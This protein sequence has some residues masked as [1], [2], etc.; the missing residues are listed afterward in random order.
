MSK[1]KIGVYVCACGINIGSK[2]DVDAVADFAAGLPNV[3][4][5]RASKYT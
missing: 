1:P 5:A 3:A 2:V 4:I